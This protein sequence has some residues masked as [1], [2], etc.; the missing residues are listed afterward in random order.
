MLITARTVRMLREEEH[1]DESVELL[2]GAGALL[3]P[4]GRKHTEKDGHSPPTGVVGQTAVMLVSVLVLLVVVEQNV[5]LLRKRPG[6]L[7]QVSKLRELPVE[8]LDE[9]ELGC[10]TRMGGYMPWFR[11]P[12][13]CPRI[14]E[15]KQNNRSE[16]A[17][18]NLRRKCMMTE[19]GRKRSMGIITEQQH[20]KDTKTG[21]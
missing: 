2:G 16:Q 21:E 1:L 14:T 7:A 6:R 9:F 4:G 15:G 8:E 11:E 3:S 5:P 19:G 13:T 18:A 17:A 10:R 20:K 12:V